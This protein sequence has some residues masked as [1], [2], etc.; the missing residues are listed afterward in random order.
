LKIILSALSLAPR[1]F[2]CVVYGSSDFS[3]SWRANNRLNSSLPNLGL[4]HP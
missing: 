2:C 4:L 3:H 1:V